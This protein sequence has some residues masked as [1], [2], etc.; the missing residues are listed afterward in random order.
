MSHSD[1]PL[2]IAFPITLAN[3]LNWLVPPGA[4]SVP[5]AL[6]PGETLAFDLPAGAAQAV[7]TLPDGKR[8]TVQAADGRAVFSNTNLLGVYQVQW[9]DGQP[10]RSR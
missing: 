3:T 5:A 4:G 7:F 2:N 8:S 10:I 9:L 1:F 6:L